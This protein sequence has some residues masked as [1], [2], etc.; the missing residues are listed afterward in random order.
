MRGSGS[1]SGAES[2]GGRA[3][4]PG[5]EDRPATGG[6]RPAAGDLGSEVDAEIG[7]HVDRVGVL[8][9]DCQAAGRS[10]WQI[11]RDVRPGGTAVGRAVHSLNF[12][13]LIGHAFHDDIDRVAARVVGVDGD[14]GD[15]EAVVVECVRAVDDGIQSEIVPGGR[16]AG[17]GIVDGAQHVAGQKRTAGGGAVHAEIDDF[18][19]GGQRHGGHGADE[20]VAIA[21]DGRNSTGKDGADGVG[22]SPTGAGRAA[23]HAAGSHQQLSVVNRVDKE[24]C[25]QRHGVAIASHIGIADDGSCAKSGWHARLGLRA[26]ID[27]DPGLVVDV[28]VVGVRGIDGHG[29][30][31]AGE[32][33]R[34]IRGDSRAL[35]AGDAVDAEAGHEGVRGI[36]DG[37]EALHLSEGAETAIEILEVRGIGGGT[38]RAGFANGVSRAPEAAV[39]AE[40]DLLRVGSVPGQ[41]VLEFA[42]LGTHAGGGVGGIAPDAAHGH[43]ALPQV[44]GAGQHQSVLAG[45]NRGQRQV[46]IAVGDGRRPLE[47][48]GL[49]SGC[50]PLLSKGDGRVAA[51]AA[52]EG[53]LVLPQALILIVAIDGPGKG[54]AG[55]GIDGKRA[56]IDGAGHVAGRRRVGGAHDGGESRARLVANT[57]PGDAVGGL[58]IAVIAHRGNKQL[59]HGIPNHGRGGIAVRPERHYVGRLHDCAAAVGNGGQMPR[60]A[61]IGGVVEAFAVHSRLVRVHYIAFVRLRD[62]SHDHLG[63][64]GTPGKT[65]KTLAG[66]DHVAGAEPIFRVGGSLDQAPGVATVGGAQDAGAVVGVENIVGIAGAGENHTGLARLHGERADAD[67]GVCRSAESRESVSQRVE[68]DVRESGRSSIAGTPHAAAGGADI[69]MVACRVRGIERNGGDAAGDEAE[70]GGKDGGGAERLP[71]DAGGV[72]GCGLRRGCHGTSGKRGAET[73]RRERAGNGAMAG[74]DSALREKVLCGCGADCVTDGDA[75]GARDCCDPSAGPKARSTRRPAAS[76]ARA[77]AARRACASARLSD[78]PAL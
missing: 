14:A 28:P 56:A 9:I 43:A 25:G 38:D 77:R 8:R 6:R 18:A 74:N 66:K 3:G 76:A 68:Y 48:A 53:T 21:G 50:I 10:V 36:D 78:F 67:G 13:F 11:G 12:L 57:C 37:R 47:G 58:V 7:G 59:A 16:G 61:A 52:T 34:P 64:D 15:V 72:V 29:T 45:G 24:W 17:G 27:G 32:N 35:H 22:R 44:V 42:H 2:Y 1:G 54:V 75:G 71:G 30:A 23:P 55:L 70:I 41:R 20:R 26:Q 5:A 33:L 4:K 60:G 51:G 69:Y 73:A 31:V 39:V 65:G 63:I 49:K 40:K 62:R 19:A 46:V